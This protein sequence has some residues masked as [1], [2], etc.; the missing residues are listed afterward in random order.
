MKLEILV[1]DYSTKYKMSL[2]NVYQKI[3]RG[4]L[5]S[6]KRNGKTYIV[7]D[8]K[9]ISTPLKKNCIKFKN[10]NKKLKLKLKIMNEKVNS[11]NEIIKSKESEINTLKITYDTLSMVI[12]SNVKSIEN[13]IIDIEPTKKNKKKN[14]K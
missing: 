4:T 2:S 1:N 3:K 11:L 6:I 8:I 9:E 13:N 10:K 5:E 7:E 14:K 12:Q